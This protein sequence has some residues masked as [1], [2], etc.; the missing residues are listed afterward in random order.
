M[1]ELVPFLFGHGVSP[2]RRAHVQRIKVIERPPPRV[3]H[4][5]ELAVDF[6]AVQFP[7]HDVNRSCLDRR[8]ANDRTIA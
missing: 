2:A 4:P 8:M 5:L 1:D 3:L 7:A 6:D